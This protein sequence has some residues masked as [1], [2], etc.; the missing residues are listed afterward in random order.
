[1]INSLG[2]NPGRN[3]MLH[4]FLLYKLHIY[5]MLVPLFQS[6]KRR[7][8]AV[9]GGDSPKMKLRWR[10]LGKQGKAGIAWWCVWRKWQERGFCMEKLLLMSFSTFRSLSECTARGDAALGCWGVGAPVPYSDDTILLISMAE[11]KIQTTKKWMQALPQN[12]TSYL[13]TGFM[14]NMLK[15]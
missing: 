7:D 1:M 8:K 12:E 14:L 6:F 3:L 4:L 10:L 13:I 11:K 9:P 15:E 2:R 5:S